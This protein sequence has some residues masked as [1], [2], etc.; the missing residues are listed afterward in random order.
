[1]TLLPRTVIIAVLVGTIVTVIPRASRRG[2][3][4]ASR[5]LRRSRST[6]RDAALPRRRVAIGLI[7]FVLGCAALVT[8]SSPRRVEVAAHR[9]GFLCVFLGVALLLQSWS[10]RSMVL[11]WPVAQIRGAPGI[12]AGQNARRNPRRTALTAA[13]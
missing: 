8:G 7:I 4:P 13:H 12:L 9:A 3:R 10:S 6:P 5:R 1:V 2:V 11:G